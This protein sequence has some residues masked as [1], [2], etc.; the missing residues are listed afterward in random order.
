MKF[1]STTFAAAVQSAIDAQKAY[2]T[3][4]AKHLKHAEYFASIAGDEEAEMKMRYSYSATFLADSFG[5]YDECMR[6][7]TTPGNRPDVFKK[8]YAVAMVQFSR[9]IRHNAL[10]PATETN[11]AS[12]IVAAEVRLISKALKGANKKQVARIMDLLEELGLIVSE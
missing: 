10:M 4:M 2:G 3:A 8:R 12:N 9:Y 11:A 7:L 5:G 1:N 6:I